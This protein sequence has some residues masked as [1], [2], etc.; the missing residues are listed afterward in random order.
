MDISSAPYKLGIITCFKG[1]QSF[2]K[3]LYELAYHLLISSIVFTSCCNS[4]LNSDM[5]S[6]VI[7]F[8]LIK[9]TISHIV[10]DFLIS[11]IT[12]GWCLSSLICFS[13][14]Q[15]FSD[16]GFVSSFRKSTYS[17]TRSSI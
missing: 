14:F 2:H 9:R 6:Y 10:S 7:T 8:N 12:P 15:N 13:N 11:I 1:F 3:L 4:S 5:S 16:A 17:L